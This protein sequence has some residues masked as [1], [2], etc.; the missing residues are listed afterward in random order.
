[1]FPLGVCVWQCISVT[2]GWKLKPSEHIDTRGRHFLRNDLCVDTAVQGDLYS[3][4]VEDRFDDFKVTVDMS[5]DK[6]KTSCN[7][8]F[9]NPCCSHIA[10]A[11]L[12]VHEKIIDGGLEE[13][14]D[15][16]FYT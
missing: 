12:K 4:S 2:V 16:N 11:L 15:S 6:L 7:C 1:M 10:A 5:G 9:L 8:H 14:L 3:F 13:D